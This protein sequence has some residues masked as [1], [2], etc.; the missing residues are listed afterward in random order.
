MPKLNIIYDVYPLG[1]WNQGTG[2]RTGIGRVGLEILK[3]LLRRDDVAVTLLSPNGIED[4]VYHTL[5]K[6]VPY[7]YTFLR[8]ENNSKSVLK[9]CSN[10]IIKNMRK[11]CTHEMRVR[12]KE[13]LPVNV[14]AGYS[15][16]DTQITNILAEYTSGQ[17]F[18]YF[19]PYYE[20]PLFIEPLQNIKKAVFVHD[21][22]PLKMPKCFINAQ[23]SMS[24]VQTIAERS[25]LVFTNS[26]FT[27]EDILSSLTCFA[28]EKIHVAYLACDAHFSRADQHAVTA[29]KVKYRIPPEKKYFLTLSTLEPRK[30]LLHVLKAFEALCQKR[31]DANICLVLAGQK[32]WKC[33]E[34][35]AS[36]SRSKD[37]IFTT[38]F[39][40]DEDLPALYSGCEAFLY[41]SE[42]EGFGLPL[43]EAMSC[44]APA[45]TANTTS[46]PEVAGDAALML[47]PR[48]L[49]GLCHAMLTLLDD[50]IF[51]Q[52]LRLAGI[53][54]AKAFSWDNC[55]ETIVQV[56]RNSG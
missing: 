6:Q 15:T 7:P 1:Q 40:A 29:V 11:Y 53:E 34:I 21:I 45:V 43:L 36:A 26:A 25:D 14:N 32:G 42:Y 46:L 22:I 37:K 12:I 39:V 33:E 52:R 44:G 17:R 13:L 4:D 30:G 3:A 2:Y 24:K 28:Q 48:D 49:N 41:M 35:R 47:P 8:L 19:S 18:W 31:P 38:G 10:F 55:A 20:P 51:S 27:R 5:C 16:H 54:Q 50:P 23:D 56:M 9:L